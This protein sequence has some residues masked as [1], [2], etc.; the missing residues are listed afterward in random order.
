MSALEWLAF[1]YLAVT[2]FH[3]N[4]RRFLIIFHGSRASRLGCIICDLSNPQWMD[5]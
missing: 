5:I 2:A 1:F 3:A 4:E